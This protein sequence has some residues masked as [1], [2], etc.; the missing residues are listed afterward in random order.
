M[1]LDQALFEHAAETGIANIRFYSWGEPARTVGYFHRF[2]P[3][4]K[5]AIRR[6]T[7]GGVVDH[8]E[9][10]TF[11]INLPK[12]SVSTGA[13]YDW[14]HRQVV[15]ALS[16]E[17]IAA[18]LESNEQTS[19]G[20]DCFALP[21]TSDILDSEG[22]KIGGGAQRRSRGSVIHQGSLRL[23]PALRDPDAGWIDQWLNGL[24]EQVEVFRSDEKQSLDKMAD[25]LVRER[26]ETQQWNQWC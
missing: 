12:C 15:G 8:G 16:R 23:P 7:G 25:K 1:A 26:Y 11:V 9:D 22:N 24:A 17:G 20:G 6:F 14:I 10:L 21:V 2:E 13:L 19:A 4:E 5:C 3:D 18:R